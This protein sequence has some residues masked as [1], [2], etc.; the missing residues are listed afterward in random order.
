MRKLL[1]AAA[2]ATALAVLPASPTPAKA[3]W[4]SEALH[5]AFDPYYYGDYYV[6][7]YNYV[8]P[9]YGGPYYDLGYDYNYPVPAYGYY[10]DYYTPYRTHYY[11]YRPGFYRPYYGARHAWHELREHYGWPEHERHEW[12]EHH[13]R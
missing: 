3:S 11:G 13:H 4:L 1:F 9:Y 12:H 5:R 10:S 8:S 2:A 7:P 6:S